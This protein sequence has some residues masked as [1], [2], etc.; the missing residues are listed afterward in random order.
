M[1]TLVH[2]PPSEHALRRGRAVGQQRAAGAGR[3][4]VAGCGGAAG[5]SAAPVGRG[6][7]R[8]G[9]AGGAGGAAWPAAALPPMEKAR[10]PRR[11]TRSCLV[12]ALRPSARRERGGAE[13]PALRVGPA[14]LASS[15]AAEGRREWGDVGGCVAQILWFI[16]GVI[17]R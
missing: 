6:G 7:S 14:R 9:P 1:S 2:L 11:N 16:S 12:P 17:S 4:P 10:R 15:R 13:G 8:A 5:L 3:V